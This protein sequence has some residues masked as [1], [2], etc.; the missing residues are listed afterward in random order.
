MGS[1]IRKIGNARSGRASTRTRAIGMANAKT[2]ST[3][4]LPPKSSTRIAAPMLSD[5]P[6]TH[7]GPKRVRLVSADS[8][9]AIVCHRRIPTHDHVSYCSQDRRPLFPP[10]EHRQGSQTHAQPGSELWSENNPVIPPRVRSEE[11]TSELQ[12]PV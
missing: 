2:T 4:A 7:S 6:R 3:R 5:E 1:P 9:A 12:S 10:A 8:T 11:H